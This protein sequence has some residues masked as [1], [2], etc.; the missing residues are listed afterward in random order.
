MPDNTQTPAPVTAAELEA[1]KILAI[2]PV[3]Y[4]PDAGAWEAIGRGGWIARS[5]IVSLTRLGLCCWQSPDENDRVITNAG[6]LVAS[7][8]TDLDAANARLDAID[9]RNDHSDITQT[10]LA[11][12]LEDALLDPMLGKGDPQVDPDAAK[13]L[14]DLRAFKSSIDAATQG[15]AVENVV[16]IVQSMVTGRDVWK[17]KCPDGQPDPLGD[18]MYAQYSDGWRKLRTAVAALVHLAGCGSRRRA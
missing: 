1:L 2:G 16:E 15:G 9:A 8:V 10:R 11:S 12:I 4:N 13:Q 7:L 5:E 6:R 3:R 18:A 17:A 14:A